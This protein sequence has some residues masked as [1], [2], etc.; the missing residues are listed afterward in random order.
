MAI[1]TD[2]NPKDR[3]LLF[4]TAGMAAVAAVAVAALLV[5]IVEHKQE[6]KNPFYRVVELNDTIDDPAPCS[7]IST[8]APW[9]WNALVMA[10]ARPCR[11]HQLK[12]I[13]ARW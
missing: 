5:N 3:R 2:K 9:T 7:T 4:I 10:A 11:I 8:C 1:S 13:R 12:A 6:A